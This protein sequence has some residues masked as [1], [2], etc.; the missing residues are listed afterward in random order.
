MLK[1]LITLLMVLSIFTTQAMASSNTG[2]KAAF[3]ELNYSLTVEWDQKDESF[4]NE[5]MSIFASKVDELKSEGL[6]QSDL[7]N[8][9]KSELKNA[10]SS[11]DLESALKVIQV[12]KLTAS[13]A[14]TY[15]L[16]AMKGSYSTGANWADNNDTLLWGTILGLGVVVYLILGTED[17][18]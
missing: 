15:V 8:F 18:I 4:Y 13:E 1:R 11:F 6:S 16:E 7:I 10:K 2:L 17:I 12:N 14:N 9:A 3:E 5:Q